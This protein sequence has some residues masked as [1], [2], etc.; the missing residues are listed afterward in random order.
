MGY[1]L[2]NWLKVNSEE[3]QMNDSLRNPHADSPLQTGQ[4]ALPAT[5]SFSTFAWALENQPAGE[6]SMTVQGGAYEHTTW[7]AMGDYLSRR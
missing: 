7:I 5:R 2:N 4:T 6:N 3:K 1:R